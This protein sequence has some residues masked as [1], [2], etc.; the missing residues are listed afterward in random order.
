[1]VL[2]GGGGVP[3]DLSLNLDV[4]IILY[5][6]SRP[7]ITVIIIIIIHI[8][9]YLKNSHLPLNPYDTDYHLA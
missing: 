9:D 8:T 3:K 4:T 2:R 7:E 5:L 1:M 6:L